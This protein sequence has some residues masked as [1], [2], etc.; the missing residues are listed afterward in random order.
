MTETRDVSADMRPVP[1]STVCFADVGDQCCLLDVTAGAYFMLNP[2]GA[3]AWRR[4]DAG[5]SLSEVHE[6]LLPQFSV[7]AETLWADL[8]VFVETLKSRGLVTVESA[9]D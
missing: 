8:R 3:A 2:V 5:S 7:S 6:A 9:C 4:F 1:V